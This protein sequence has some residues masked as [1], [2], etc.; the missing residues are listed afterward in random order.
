MKNLFL[1]VKNVKVFNF[2]ECFPNLVL[3]LLCNFLLREKQV[4]PDVVSEL[5]KLTE[6]YASSNL[7]ESLPDSLGKL[8]NLKILNVSGNKLTSVPDSICSCKYASHF[9]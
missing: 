5:E 7:L 4:I 3:T 1:K 6:L 2:L 8:K 9:N